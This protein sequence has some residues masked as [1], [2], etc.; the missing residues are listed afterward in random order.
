M[1]VLLSF[2]AT[3]IY[4]FYSICSIIIIMTIMIINTVPYLLY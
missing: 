2:Y 1:E 4:T 3:D